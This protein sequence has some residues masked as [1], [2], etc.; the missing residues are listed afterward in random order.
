MTAT[1]DANDILLAGG[2]PTAKFP[3]IGTT[4]K[5]V[6]ESLEV[7]QQTDINGTL[8]FWP[9]G[10][11]KMQVVVTLK[12]DES[13]PAIDEDDGSRRLFVKGYMQNAVRDALKAANSRLEVGGTLAVKFDH[14]VPPTKPG[15]SATKMYVAQYKPGVASQGA[16][17]DLL[18]GGQETP[19]PAAAAPTTAA[20][21]I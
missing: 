19:T 17:D 16:V 7:T 18:G 10:K 12:T 5:G 4:V 6:V 20:D 9:N 3:T 14:E 21:L 15:H 1:Q 11:E 8:L 13:D 2:A